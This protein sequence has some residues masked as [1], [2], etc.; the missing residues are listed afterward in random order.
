VAGSVGCPE[1][2]SD[3]SR[4]GELARGDCDPRCSTLWRS[5]GIRGERLCQ[6]TDHRAV[7]QCHGRARIMPW[8]CGA[9]MAEHLPTGSPDTRQQPMASRPGVDPPCLMSRK[10]PLLDAD[11][12]NYPGDKANDRRKGE[13]AHS[14]I[15]SANGNQTDSGR[16]RHHQLAEVGRIPHQSVR[17][18]DHQR[19]TRRQEPE[20]VS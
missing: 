8:P 13:Y 5:P 1:N 7:S 19:S 20:S 12:P 3:P 9:L 14:C 10:V 4:F 16:Q 11:A 15:R 18:R 17:P 2:V 6:R